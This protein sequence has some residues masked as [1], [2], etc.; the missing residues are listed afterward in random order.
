MEVGGDGVPLDPFVQAVHF[1]DDVGWP[2][3]LHLCSSVHWS[4]A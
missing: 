4:A 2:E 1:V 3:S